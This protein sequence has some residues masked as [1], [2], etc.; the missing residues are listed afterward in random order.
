MIKPENTVSYTF[1]SYDNMSSQA[2]E[3][4]SETQNGKLE[5]EMAD[6]FEELTLVHREIEVRPVPAVAEPR[7]KGGLLSRLGRLFWPSATAKA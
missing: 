7:R 1:R 6:W 3:R 4:Y 2:S 5:M